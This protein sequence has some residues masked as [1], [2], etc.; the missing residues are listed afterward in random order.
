MQ[1]R[2]N[3]NS[4]SGPVPPLRC[5]VFALVALQASVFVSASS[6]LEL[7]KSGSTDFRIVL[8]K[9][10]IPA[11]QTAAQELQEY[12]HRVTGAFVPVSSESTASSSSP[13]ILV[14]VGERVRKYLAEQK[15]SPPVKDGIL[16]KTLPDAL[17]LAGGRPRGSLYAVYTFLEDTVGV[18]WWTSSEST[19]PRKPT[20]CIPELD[21]R[22]SPKLCTGK[23]TTA[24]RSAIH[25]SPPG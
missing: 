7:T 24:S 16:I 15:L 6:A 11:E 25:S 13:Q 10:A 21:I 5:V 20:L 12:F 19:V 3:M 4:H 22:Y 18:R 17:I 14:G 8:P 23:L 2:A 1:A 9:D